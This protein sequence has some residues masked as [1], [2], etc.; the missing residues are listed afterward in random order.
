MPKNKKG[1]GDQPFT[2]GFSRKTGWYD[3]KRDNRS[4]KKQLEKLKCKRM[5]AQNVNEYNLI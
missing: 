1:H 3:P 2:P 5:S 4:I